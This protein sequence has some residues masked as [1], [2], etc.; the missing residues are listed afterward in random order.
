[1]DKETVAKINEVLNA[2]GKRELCT[3]KELEMVVGGFF[4]FNSNN[5]TMEYTH[6]DGSTTIH[7][8]IDME[9]AWEISNY[10]HGKHI[11]EDDILKQ[12]VDYNYI[13]Q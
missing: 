3:D 11:P 4:H 5:K 6:E 9:K 8:V 7:R 12:L 2:N 1:M 10:L 13:E